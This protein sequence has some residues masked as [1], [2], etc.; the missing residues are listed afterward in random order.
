MKIFSI[1]IFLLFL[2][3]LINHSQG[4]E[5]KIILSSSNYSIV[6]LENS[7]VLGSE[8]QGG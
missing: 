4:L 1:L 6:N 5:N 8:K 3:G 7:K 2:F